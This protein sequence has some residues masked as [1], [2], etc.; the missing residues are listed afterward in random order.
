MPGEL[1]LTPRSMIMLEGTGSDFDQAY[2][3]DVIERRLHQ[4]GGFTQHIRAKNTSPRTDT[5][6]PQ[7]PA[8]AGWVSRMERLLNVVKQHAGAIGSRM[9]ASRALAQSHRW[10]RQPRLRGSRCSRKAFSP[11]GCRFCHPGSEPVGACVVLRRLVIRFWFSR[12]RAMPTMAS[13]SDAHSRTRKSRRRHQSAKSGWSIAPAAS[14]SC[15]M[16]G[17]FRC[18]VICMWLAMFTTRKAL[19]LVCAAIT[20]AYHTDSRGGTTSVTNQPD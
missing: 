1:L 4:T 9:A 11:A 18:R 10:I 17:Q 5:T 2:F 15:R 3:V 7:V 12:R 14:S 6:T 8:T 16:T 20:T 13:S 19:C